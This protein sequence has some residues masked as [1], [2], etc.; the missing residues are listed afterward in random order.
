MT[1]YATDI[2]LLNNMTPSQWAGTAYS[3]L[4]SEGARGATKIPTAHHTLPAW[5]L[6]R[7]GNVP[8]IGICFKNIR[9]SSVN[10]A[11][12]SAGG[13]VLIIAPRN[14]VGG[15]QCFEGTLLLAS[16]ADDAGYIYLRIHGNR[17]PDIAV[18]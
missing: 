5:Q 18:L 7:P 14:V 12:D 15:Y 6:G 3:C 16:S 4:A 13:Y 2:V 10:A 11:W 9:T 1:L 17:L 8:S